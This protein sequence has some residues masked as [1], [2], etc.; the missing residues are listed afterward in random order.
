[1]NGRTLLK[2]FD[3]FKE[4][5]GAGRALVKIFHNL[6]PDGQGKLVFR[7]VPVRDYACVN[8]IEITD[9]SP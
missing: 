4:A 6:V 7:V 9:E 2:D 8:A 5:G 3:I 1:M